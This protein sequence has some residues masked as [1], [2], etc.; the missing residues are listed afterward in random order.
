MRGLVLLTPALALALAGCGGGSAA[1]SPHPTSSAPAKAAPSTP[2]P[3]PTPSPTHREKA[4]SNIHACYDGTCVLKVRGEVTIPL[5]K[6]KFSYSEVQIE[7][8]SS[9]GLTY[10]VPF[11]G[12]GGASGELGPNPSGS[13]A[14]FGKTGHPFIEIGVISIKHGT[15]LLSLR[16]KPHD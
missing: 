2:K 8:F 4:T 7:K 9:D 11:G 16:A 5:N 6:K 14:E 13:G 12:G 3:S 15:A 1:P 10:F